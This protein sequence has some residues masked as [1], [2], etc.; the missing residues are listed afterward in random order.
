MEIFVDRVDGELVISEAGCEKQLLG[1]EI[2][3]VIFVS[4]N[5]NTEGRP[6]IASM[7]LKDR[8]NDLARVFL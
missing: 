3:G 2:F 5:S 8:G 1:T 6:I 4:G 7:M